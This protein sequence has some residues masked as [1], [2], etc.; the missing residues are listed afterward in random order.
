ME[1]PSGNEWKRGALRGVLSLAATLVFLLLICAGMDKTLLPLRSLFNLSFGVGLLVA[2]LSLIEGRALRPSLG[3]D[4]GWAVLVCAGAVLLQLAVMA[5]D[6]YQ[7]V[8]LQTGDP[9]VASQE[10]SSLVGD[11]WEQAELYLSLAS[12][13]ALPLGALLFARLQG[14]GLWAHI[15]ASELS[16]AGLGFPAWVSLSVLPAS[17]GKPEG[18]GLAF[19]LPLAMAGGL[20]ILDRIER[21][22]LED[23]ELAPEP[24]PSR[25]RG[26]EGFGSA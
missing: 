22:V 14:W 2:C 21:R 7:T 17:S 16:L 5:G 23:R 10:A 19:L 11:L 26:G 24:A 3:R 1:L 13:I 9:R 12:L 20:A 6:V 18:L 4:F 25:R 8:L 15:L